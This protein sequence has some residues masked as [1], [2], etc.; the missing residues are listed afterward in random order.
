MAENLDADRL[1]FGGS[2]YPPPDI[3]PARHRWA[4]L[5]VLAL[6]SAAIWVAAVYLIFPVL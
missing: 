6:A 3:A 2:L 5:I 1:I 4:A